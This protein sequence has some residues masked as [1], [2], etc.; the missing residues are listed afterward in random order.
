[1]GLYSGVYLET[2]RQSMV[3][4]FEERSV[5]FEGILIKK[6]ICCTSCI[7]REPVIVVQAE[8]FQNSMCL[9]TPFITRP[10]SIFDAFL[11]DNIAIKITQILP[12][13]KT[14]TK[15]SRGKNDVFLHE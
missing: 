6:I 3:E 10:T 8:I 2:W 5:Y 14:S 13:V 7:G 12:W 9:Y 11:P 1:M 4:L 15:K